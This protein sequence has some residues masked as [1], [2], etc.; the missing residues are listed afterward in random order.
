[1]TLL[2]FNRIKRFA[3]LF[4]LQ[5]GKDALS[6]ISSEKRKI[7]IVFISGGYRIA[8]EAFQRSYHAL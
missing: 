3:F 7:S 1:M 5:R 6:N 8:S 4:F 2:H